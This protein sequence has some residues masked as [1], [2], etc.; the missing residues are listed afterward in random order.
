MV[1]NL[2]ETDTGFYY[3]IL[4][5]CT[6]VVHASLVKFDKLDGYHIIFPIK[7]DVFRYGDH[8]FLL[9]PSENSKIVYLFETDGAINKIEGECQVLLPQNSC[10]QI[11]YALIIAE[12]EEKVFIDWEEYYQGYW[13]RWISVLRD[14]EEEPHPIEH[15]KMMVV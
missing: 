11:D 15:R 9:P 8:I 5:G 10:E 4:C 6:I 1:L 7:C 13:N 12:P 14:G 3:N 2:F